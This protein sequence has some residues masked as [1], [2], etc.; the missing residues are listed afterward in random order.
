MPEIS[1]PVSCVSC[2]LSGSVN[3]NSVYE[4]LQSSRAQVIMLN[5]FLSANILNTVQT[6]GFG[7]VVD[8]WVMYFQWILTRTV[9]YIRKIF[10]T[11]SAMVI[12]SHLFFDEKGNRFFLFLQAKRNWCLKV[13]DI[14]LSFQNIWPQWY[15]KSFV[16]IER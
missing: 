4:Y 15:K 11:L 7:K 12:S 2:R 16:I 6:F 1:A 5:R 9:I 14:L 13:T 10:A 8:C 3:P